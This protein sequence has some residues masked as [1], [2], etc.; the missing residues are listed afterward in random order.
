MI[1]L[2]LNELAAKSGV[3]AS[4]LLGSHRA[5]RAL[6]LSPYSTKDA[7]PLGFDEDKL[8]TLARFLSQS[9]PVVDENV[10]ASRGG[11]LAPYAASLLA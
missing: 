4:H 7:K 8:F 6:C 1:P 11:R 3:S 10:P 2:T 9:S 5:S